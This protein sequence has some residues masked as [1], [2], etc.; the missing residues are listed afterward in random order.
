M[1]SDRIRE[2]ADGLRSLRLERDL[3]IMEVCGT[4]TTEF[5]RSG[6]RDVFPEGLSLIDGPGCPVCVTPND[7]LD[8]AIEIARVHGVTVAT[9]GDMVK[10]PS[11]YSSLAREKSTGMR[12]EVVYSPLDAL[13]FAAV[14]Q[15]VQV[16]FLSV[17]FETTAPTEAVAV[18]RARER[19]ILNFSILCGNK[20]TPPAVKALLDAGETRI[21]GFIL[22]GHVSAIIG[23][24]PWRF[25]AESYHKPCVVAG[26]ESYDLITSTINL[27]RMIGEQRNV[28][29][30]GYARVVRDGGNPKAREIMYDVF[31][32]CEAHWRG[33]GVIPGSGLAL[34]DG[35]AGF[36]AAR[37]FPV[38]PPA[39]RQH[40]G[41]RC[42]DLLRG[43]IIPTGCGLF[44]T[45]CTPE[46]A[47]GPCMVSSEGPCS[48]YYKYGG[49]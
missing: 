48:A 11:S 2:M 28:V 3:R 33:I 42:G 17:G 49:M 40:P 35:Y 24:E 8:R 44:G 5:F 26:F 38:D 41:C 18:R 21:D 22:P 1:K 19:N 4:H 16:M 36:D 34:R 23:V 47:V 37:R 20:L 12:L 31:E 25:V 6:V 15:D 29:E 10:V 43:L 32:E 13:E 39:P 45:A 30:N 46:N 14:N 9:F 7:Y 27:V